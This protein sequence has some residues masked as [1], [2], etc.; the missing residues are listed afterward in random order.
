MRPVLL[1]IFPQLRIDWSLLTNLSPTRWSDGTRRPWGSS[2]TPTFK[3]RSASEKKFHSAS[4]C[5]FS[6]R[7]SISI[8]G[9]RPWNSA[10]CLRTS[11]P[12]VTTHLLRGFAMDLQRLDLAQMRRYRHRLQ[13]LHK[14]HPFQQRICIHRTLHAHRSKPKTFRHLGLPQSQDVRCLNLGQRSRW[15]QS[16][17]LSLIQWGSLLTFHVQNASHLLAPDLKSKGNFEPTSNSWK[18]AI[19]KSSQALS[20]W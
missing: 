7:L 20:T 12:Q 19:A 15:R 14:T 11:Q 13:L 3:E 1:W 10:L 9:T 2:T 4:R 6:S 8:L 5:G 16:S 18:T 17:R